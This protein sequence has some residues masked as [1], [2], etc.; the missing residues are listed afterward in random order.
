MTQ[1]KTVFNYGQDEESVFKFKKQYDDS[2]DITAAAANFYNKRNDE[3]ISNTDIAG[4]QKQGKVDMDGSV[5]LNQG[6]YGCVYHPVIRCDD[7]KNNQ[8][9]EKRSDNYISKIKFNDKS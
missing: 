3:Y 9:I 7:N 4:I 2:L 8:L 5:L 1:N 6:G